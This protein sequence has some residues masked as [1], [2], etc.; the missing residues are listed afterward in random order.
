M[1]DYRPTCDSS[2]DDTTENESWSSS[3]DVVKNE[4]T[5]LQKIIVEMYIDVDVAGKSTNKNISMLDKIDEAKGRL[6]GMENY[7][8]AKDT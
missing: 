2:D 5:K 7:F 1:P 4:L 3:I 8:R 6:Q